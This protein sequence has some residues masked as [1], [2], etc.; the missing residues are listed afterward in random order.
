[1]LRG[2]I[3]V[4]FAGNEIAWQPVK[5]RSNICWLCCVPGSVPHGV[6]FKPSNNTSSKACLLLTGNQV[7]CPL[8]QRGPRLGLQAHLAPKPMPFLLWP[9]AINEPR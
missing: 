3:Q 5:E 4:A 1:M 9:L 6:S 7:S 8:L 2:E